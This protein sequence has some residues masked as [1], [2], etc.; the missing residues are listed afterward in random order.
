MLCLQSLCAEYV[1]CEFIIDIKLKIY[2]NIRRDFSM[3][4][5]SC[6]KRILVFESR[7]AKSQLWPVFTFRILDF[8][9]GTLFS[10]TVRLNELVKW[11]L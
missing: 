8:I 11:E 9:N 6:T 1:L 4:L 2:A 3:H 10:K 5:S 7:A